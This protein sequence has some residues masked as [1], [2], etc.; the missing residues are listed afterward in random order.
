MVSKLID[1]ALGVLKLFMFKVSVIIVI[2]KI[3]FF[4]FSLTER[5]KQNQKK[6]ETIQ[7]PLSL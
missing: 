2:S 7:N 5:V 3:N 4:S 6:L 1:L